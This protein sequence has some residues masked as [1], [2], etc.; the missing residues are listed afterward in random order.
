MSILERVFK[1]KKE[2]RNFYNVNDAAVD[3]GDSLQVWRVAVNI[4]NTHC[5]Q[6]KM[7]PTI[8]HNKKVGHYKMLKTALGWIS[9]YKHEGK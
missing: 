3:G 6:L 2:Y 4:L 8:P 5:K 9:S 1:N 7:G